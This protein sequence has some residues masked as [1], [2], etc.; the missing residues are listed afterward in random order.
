MPSMNGNSE[1]FDFSQWANA[2]Q[3]SLSGII[4]RES[5]RA[6]YGALLSDK[7]MEEV[8]KMLFRM[9]QRWDEHDVRAIIANYGDASLIQGR[10][11]KDKLCK[12]AVE[13]IIINMDPE[14]LE[15]LAKRTKYR[16]AGLKNDIKKNDKAADKRGKSALLDMMKQFQAIKDA[17][18]YQDY[19]KKLR[20]SEGINPGNILRGHYAKLTK[21][22]KEFLKTQNIL[23]IR[24]LAAELGIEVDE[25]DK[26]KRNDLTRQIINL[27]CLYVDIITGKNKNLHYGNAI[28]NPKPIQELLRYTSYG[29]LSGNPG[30]TPAEGRRLREEARRNKAIMSMRLKLMKSRSSTGSK[31]FK[32]LTGVDRTMGYRDAVRSL[33]DN[34][35]GVLRDCTMEQILDLAVNY[36]IDPST[37]DIGKLKLQIYRAMAAEQKALEKSERSYARRPTRAKYDNLS[38]RQSMFAA[39]TRNNDEPDAIV[40]VLTDVKDGADRVTGKYNQVEVIANETL[41]KFMSLTLITGSDAKLTMASAVLESNYIGAKD[42]YKPQALRLNGLIT[43]TIAYMYSS[44]KIRFRVIFDSLRYK[45]D[46]G[47]HI[48][49]PRGNAQTMFDEESRGVYKLKKAYA[50]YLAYIYLIASGENSAAEYIR[51]KYGMRKKTIKELI[52]LKDRAANLAARAGKK[53]L[54]TTIGQVIKGVVNVINFIT[55]K[56]KVYQTRESLSEDDRDFLGELESQSIGGLKEVC[57]RKLYIDLSSTSLSELKDADS[58]KQASAGKGGYN[59]DAIT[60]G[61]PEII[62]K[63]ILI[64]II[65]SMMKRKAICA[66]LRFSVLNK[67]GLG[68]RL[69]II[70]KYI[71]SVLKKAEG[72]FL[73]KLKKLSFRGLKDRFRRYGIGGK[74]GGG[75][76]SARS[77]TKGVSDSEDIIDL[78]I[79]SEEAPRTVGVPQIISNLSINNISLGN[80]DITGGI[81]NFFSIFNNEDIKIGVSQFFNA[82]QNEDVSIGL[83][84]FFSIFN[85]ETTTFINNTSFWQGI[86]NYFSMFS[87]ESNINMIESYENM[88]SIFSSE[89][90]TKQD[91][92]LIS[93]G[94]SSFFSIFSGFTSNDITNTSTGIINFFSM[95]SDTNNNM[96]MSTGIYNLLYSYSLYNESELVDISRGRYNF[97]NNFSNEEINIGVTNFFNMFRPENTQ[98]ANMVADIHAILEILQDGHRG[99]VGPQSMR[100]Q[101]ADETAHL[102]DLRN[103]IDA[104]TGTLRASGLSDAD[105]ARDTELSILN[106]EYSSKN[107]EL[108]EAQDFYNS[109]R[110]Y[111]NFQ[112]G[113]EA[114]KYLNTAAKALRFTRVRKALADPVF[115]VNKM[116]G[117]SNDRLMKKLIKVTEESGNGIVSYLETAFPILALSNA[118]PLT[119]G[120]MAAV[121]AFTATSGISVAAD[122]AA[123]VAGIDDDFSAYAR[124]S[125]RVRSIRKGLPV[126]PAFATGTN[127]FTSG[128]YRNF[129][130]QA[131]A[132]VTN[133]SYLNNISSLGKTVDSTAFI[134]G[135]SLTGG[136]NPELVN[137]DWNHKTASVKPI[138]EDTKFKRSLSGTMSKYERELPMSVSVKNNLVSLL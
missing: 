12:Q 125:N 111:T 120:A 11:S 6:N 19:A 92:S 95:F 3:N 5:N 107:N 38:T 133:T 102:S 21:E 26:L 115:V 45:D 76:R 36:G 127:K 135:D 1:G 57:S 32:K 63:S 15:A 48:I 23:E 39:N 17:K 69:D 70:M 4:S 67:D 128:Q 132:A 74:H 13:T 121:P 14:E 85:D 78:R 103:Q 105:I 82:F 41:D 30:M 83:S 80:V 81:S 89:N 66:Y 64:Y 106:D 108:Q 101:F 16:V 59:F 7:R 137:I 113:I 25:K 54:N 55:D 119:P 29:F 117:E 77:L 56:E 51:K 88:L 10:M 8:R 123:S 116:D 130:N 37:R 122:I 96:Y 93:I 42:E 35:K 62:K 61:L 60:A 31:N 53:I 126:I 131:K 90:I 43:R 84:N 75:A 91:I 50:A 46:Y 73:N 24:N 27:V 44:L 79:P 109:D 114:T 52:A 65:A 9:V 28:T 104:R 71:R 47:T 58:D 49:N 118:G 112:H 68:G 136:G 87:S 97:F 100:H 94:L 33:R 40:S 98:G 18:N 22:L 134:S 34:D 99:F 20:K 124:G 72:K 86:S 129:A 138:P 2:D 110:K